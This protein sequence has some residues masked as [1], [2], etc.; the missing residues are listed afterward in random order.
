MV[1]CLDTLILGTAI[2][3]MSMATEATALRTYLITKM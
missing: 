3:V 1:L 2:Q